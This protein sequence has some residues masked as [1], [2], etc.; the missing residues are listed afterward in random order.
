[1]S[2]IKFEGTGF[3]VEYWKKFSQSDFVTTLLKSKIYSNYSQA[4]R[5]KMFEEVHKQ[6]T[7]GNTVGTKKETSDITRTAT[8]DKV[9]QHTG[10]SDNDS[11]TNDAGNIRVQPG[12]TT[13][14]APQ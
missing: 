14:R 4:D 6:I 12:T 5:K 9:V 10:S 2:T 11:R 8:A 3:N 13:E 1:M 7:G